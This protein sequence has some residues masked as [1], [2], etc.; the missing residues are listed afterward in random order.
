MSARPKVHAA[1]D[2]P[3][4]I[5]TAEHDRRRFASA[6]PTRAQ[7]REQQQIGLILDDNRRFRS[8]MTQKSAQRAFFSPVAGR[9]KERSGNASRHNAGGPTRDGS[10]LLRD[11]APLPARFA[12]E[13]EG[14]SNS[15]PSIPTDPGRSLA[16]FATTL[17][18]LG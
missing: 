3:P 17:A 16:G 12:P 5:E 9:E 8:Q 6:R 18:A 10:C 11:V 4:G 14:P 2:H 7:G 15:G 13:A 1:K